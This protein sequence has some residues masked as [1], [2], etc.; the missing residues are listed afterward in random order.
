MENKG[1]KNNINKILYKYYVK[2]IFKTN[3]EW[4]KI[5]DNDDNNDDKMKNYY[6]K[7]IQ[8]KILHNKDNHL[9]YINIMKELQVN[10]KKFNWNV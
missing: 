7:Y 8:K 6:Y 5:Y 1:N 2:K 9:L 4:Y 10:Y 3:V